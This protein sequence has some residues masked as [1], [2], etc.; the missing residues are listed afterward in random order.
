MALE[1]LPPGEI[2]DH[3]LVSYRALRLGASNG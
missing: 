1:S 2:A 3:L